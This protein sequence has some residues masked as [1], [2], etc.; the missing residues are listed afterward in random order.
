MNKQQLN[1]EAVFKLLTKA[2]KLVDGS[3]IFTDL[4][5][6]TFL[7]DKD[8]D[9][10]TVDNNKVSYCNKG[11]FSQ[12]ENGYLYVKLFVCIDG[13]IK[14]I[15]YAQHSIV[16]A[17]F[18]DVPYDYNRIVNHKDNCPFNNH[19][20]N[21]EWTTHAL[22]VLHGRVAATATAIHNNSSAL[23]WL[24]IFDGI[25]LYCQTHNAK[26]VFDSLKIGISCYDL[27]AYEQYIL[28][29]NQRVKSLKQYWGLTNKDVSICNYKYLEFIKWWIKRN[30]INIKEV[31]L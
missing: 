11:V 25:D 24:E 3:F 30:H 8:G 19:P 26:Y 29:I 9:M 15:N 10:F 23:Q 14:R 7:V 1:N 2:T 22:N 12:K 16:C 28:E 6:T 17:L 21:L 4:S 13:Q 31:T 18:N 20:D 27:V 5:N